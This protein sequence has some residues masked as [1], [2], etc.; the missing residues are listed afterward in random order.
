MSPRPLRSRPRSAVALALAA[1]WAYLA[2]SSNRTFDAPGG[3][4][5]GSESEGGGGTDGGRASGGESG[6]DLGGSSAAGLSGA[7]GGEGRGAA[8]GASGAGV[9]GSDGAGG[10]G[11]EPSC[12]L[13]RDCTPPD[14]LLCGR[15]CLEGTCSFALASAAF[16]T[17]PETEQHRTSGFDATGTPYVFWGDSAAEPS[18]IVIQQ[19]QG[20]GAPAGASVSY[21][22]PVGTDELLLF[23]ATFQGNALGLIWNAQVPSTEEIVTQ[24][25][26]TDTTAEPYAPV[27]L[28]RSQIYD[29]YPQYAYT[30]LAWPSGGKWLLSEFYGRAPARWRATWL[31]P[32]APP[33]SPPFLDSPSA[34]QG[35]PVCSDQG[36][37]AQSAAVVGSTLYLSG[38]ACDWYQIADCPVAMLLSRYD[39]TTLQPLQPPRLELTVSPV[40]YDASLMVRAPVLGGLAGKVAVFWNE[41]LTPPGL[42]LGKALFNADG[43][44]AKSRSVEDSALIPKAFVELGGGRGLL[45]SSRV[46]DSVEPPRH[47]LEAQLVDD[48]LEWL[49]AAAPLDQA[50]AEEP[51]D[52]EASLSPD[53]SRVLVTFRQGRARHRLLHATLCQ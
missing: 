10:S 26:V 30:H 53:G 33:A 19:L 13:A 12:S 40:D 11:A 16:A 22:M 50:R 21:L 17:G 8:G 32:A 36:R 35:A 18:S 43:S 46:D 5:A 49:G 4:S 45:L 29:K 31:D 41:P 25:D 48:E 24:F 15:A 14:A 42:Q 52:V 7:S 27:T 28:S 9:G 1:G 39:S 6:E 2:C 3:G 38:F 23:D 47:R 20:D 44:V 34:L 37:V 51:S